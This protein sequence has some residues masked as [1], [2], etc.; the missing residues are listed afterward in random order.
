MLFIYRYAGVNSV[1]QAGNVINLKI[2]W[3]F[4]AGSGTVRGWTG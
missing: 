3:T 1:N 4:G 2:E